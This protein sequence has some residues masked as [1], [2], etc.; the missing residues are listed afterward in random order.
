M[1]RT[2]DMQSEIT[3]K[4]CQPVMRANQGFGVLGKEE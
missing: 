2:Y 4:F 3:S 1:V